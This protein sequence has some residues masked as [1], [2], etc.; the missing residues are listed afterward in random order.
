MNITIISRL[1]SVVSHPN[2]LATGSPFLQ[3]HIMP[4]TLND[5]TNLEIGAQSKKPFPWNME[6]CGSGGEDVSKPVTVPITSVGPVIDFNQSNRHEFGDLIRYAM[7]APK[8]SAQV[9]GCCADEGVGETN[10]MFPAK[11]PSPPPTHCTHALRAR[12]VSS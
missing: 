3:K 7:R 2:Y 6:S 10:L 11:L 8:A 12:Q 1:L 5:N 9:L 4:S